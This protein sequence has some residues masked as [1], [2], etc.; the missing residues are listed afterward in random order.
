MKQI[1]SKEEVENEGL[2]NHYDIQLIVM[3]EEKKGCSIT[4]I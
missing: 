2:T 1:A 3:D 4:N